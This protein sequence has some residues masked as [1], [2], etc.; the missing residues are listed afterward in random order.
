MLLKNKKSARPNPSTEEGVWP[1]FVS[2]QSKDMETCGPTS[3]TTLGSGRMSPVAGN[4]F[5][6]SPMVSTGFWSASKPF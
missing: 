1:F 3:G 6:M 4:G 5:S 2:K